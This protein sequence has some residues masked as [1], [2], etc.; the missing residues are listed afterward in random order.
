V[1]LRLA[2]HEARS[3]ADKITG[4]NLGIKEQEIVIARLTE[5]VNAKMYTDS[6]T[7]LTNRKFLEQLWETNANGLRNGDSEGEAMDVDKKTE[8]T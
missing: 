7:C 6:G 4:S 2:F 5:Q 3:E 8:E 1:Q